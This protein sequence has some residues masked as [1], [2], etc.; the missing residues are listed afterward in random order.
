MPSGYAHY[1]FGAQL[2]PGLPPEVRRTISRHRGLYDMGLHGPDIFLYYNPA[3]RNDVAKLSEK[4]HSQ[5]GLTFFS[6]VCKRHRLEPSEPARAYLYG[7][8]AH[9]CLDALCHPFVYLH[10]RDG[11]LGHL[12]VETEFDRY[13]LDKDGKRPPH[14]QDCS[15][16]MKLTEAQCAVAAGFYPNVTAGE[17]AQCT[18]NMARATRLLA[19]PNPTF[20][21]VMTA[22][23]GITGKYSQ[24]L[25][26]QGPDPRCAPLDPEL[27]TLYDR[28]LE[29]Y[30]RLLRQILANL[31]CG[32]AL[33]QD[34]E[35]P[36]DIYEEKESVAK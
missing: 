6:R 14:T 20:R 5:S 27:E 23:L 7:L 25:M 19:S 18:R 28:A 13:L 3:V 9:Y 15:L 31:T 2:L 21:K 11:N 29:L 16:H 24:M 30:P 34:F 36:F 17:I 8:L 10:T 35:P 1:R 4:F 22:V 32:V 33:G 26:T 12:E